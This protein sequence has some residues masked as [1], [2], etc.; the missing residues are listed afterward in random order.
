MHLDRAKPRK[1]KEALEKRVAAKDDRYKN[2]RNDVTARA[3][4]FAHKLIHEG[5][6]VVKDI[7]IED[8]ILDNAN[9]YTLSN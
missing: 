4:R 8:T 9:Q 1:K 3:I 6:I 2:T 5:S 7:D